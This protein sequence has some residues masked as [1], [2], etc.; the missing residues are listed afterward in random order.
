M[1]LQ[2]SIQEDLKTAMKQKDTVA[3]TTLRAIKSAILLVQTEKDAKALDAAGEIQLLQK[4]IKQRQDAADIYK[5]QNREDL[6]EKE[7][8]EIAIIKKYL[9]EQLSAEELTDIIKGVITKVGAEGPK[10]MGKVMGAVGKEIA[11]R[12]DNK[13]V[14]STVK[15]L[16]S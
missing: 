6:A 11:G 2:D 8:G 10:D 13:L 5:E 15:T 16:L 3:L 7:L 14:A 9:P 4:Q 12:A 1:S